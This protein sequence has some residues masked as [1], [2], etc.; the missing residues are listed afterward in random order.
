[1]KRN[2][3]ESLSKEYLEYLGI[4]KV[5]E[6][7]KEI[8]KDDKLLT[9]YGD[10]DGYLKVSLYDPIKRQQVP[11]ECRTASSGVLCLGVHRLVYAWFNNFIPNGIVIDHI[12][13][14]K[15]DNRLENLQPLTPSENVWKGRICHIREIPCSLSRPREY[16]ETKLA[17]YEELY[18][19]AKLD[20][21][22]VEAHKQRTNIA[23]IRARLRYYDSH[24]KEVNEM[25]E[26][27][28]D[29]AELRAWKKYFKEQGNKTMWH[30]CCKVE[31]VA[32]TKETKDDA[33]IIVKHAIDVLHGHFS[34]SI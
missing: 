5:S 27:Q 24:I 12:N 11:Q 19:Q 17:K 6:D 23:N 18:N 14:C 9:Q 31:K 22:A 13:N 33:A 26:Y 3:A 15:T 20:H 10:Q 8:W 21:N 34:C 16:Y 7:G 32:K 4:T 2:Y 28:K 29:L 25:T 1:M 30:E